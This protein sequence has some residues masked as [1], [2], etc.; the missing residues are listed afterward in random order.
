MFIVISTSIALSRNKNVT[1]VKSIVLS[2]L[3]RLH[4][5]ISIENVFFKRYFSIMTMSSYAFA[6]AIT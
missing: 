4:V 5:M 2:L 1:K 6:F 3:S